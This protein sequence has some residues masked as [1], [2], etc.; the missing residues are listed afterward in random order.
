MDAQ[1][2]PCSPWC[3]GVVGSPAVADPPLS[4]LC[5]EP[6]HCG[7]CLLQSQ[8]LVSNYIQDAAMPDHPC[9]VQGRGLLATGHSLV[10]IPSQELPPQGTA[11]PA[12]LL[13]MS[14]PQPMS[15]SRSCDQDKEGYPSA[16][17]HSIQGIFPRPLLTCCKQVCYA[18]CT[19]LV[20]HNLQIQ[21]LSCSKGSPTE[22][23]TPPGA[24]SK[25][26]VGGRNF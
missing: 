18:L 4:P 20:S 16:S 15:W 13:W 26:G 8:L 12:R 7:H 25:P 19:T 23:I 11:V 10:P 24:L 1:H 9:H 5:P 3:P 17:G 2:P 21:P 14:A 22:P 6:S